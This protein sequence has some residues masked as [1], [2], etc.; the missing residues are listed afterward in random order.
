MTKQQSF[1]DFFR[2]ASPE[3]KRRLFLEAARKANEDQRELLAKATT[4]DSKSMSV[5]NFNFDKFFATLFR[6][7]SLKLANR[8]AKARRVKVRVIRRKAVKTSRVLS[9]V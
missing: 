5:K 2:N 4:S 6:T 1:T 7:G 8:A 3:E 9:K